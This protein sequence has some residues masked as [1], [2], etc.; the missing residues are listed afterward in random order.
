[1]NLNSVQPLIFR[2]KTIPTQIKELTTQTKFVFPSDYAVARGIIA[3]RRPSIVPKGSQAG[4]KA[5]ERNL[6]FVCH[7]VLR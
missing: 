2:P 7:R 3:L 6:F 1:M 4:D 5:K